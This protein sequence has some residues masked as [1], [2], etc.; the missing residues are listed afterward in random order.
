MSASVQ[1]FVFDVSIDMGFASPQRCEM[2]L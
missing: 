1:G 2:Y